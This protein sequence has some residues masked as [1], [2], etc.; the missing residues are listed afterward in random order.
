MNSSVKFFVPS[1]SVPLL[2]EL[3]LDV[4]LLAAAPAPD[5]D[6]LELELDPHAA[7]NSAANTASAT[8]G[9]ERRPPGPSGL[10]GVFVDMHSS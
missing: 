3:E 8:S 4:E 1:V 10:R 5:V 7:M 2:E 9:S 6:E